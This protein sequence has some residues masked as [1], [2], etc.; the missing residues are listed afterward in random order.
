MLFT[1]GY[2]ISTEKDNYDEYGW[3]VWVYVPFTFFISGSYVYALYFTASLVNQLEREL[4]DIKEDNSLLLLGALFFFP[5]GI[6]WI[7]PRINRI[8]ETPILEEAEET[9]T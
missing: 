1:N 3:L 7:Q 8:L 5:I 4:F 2:S 9:S 6:W